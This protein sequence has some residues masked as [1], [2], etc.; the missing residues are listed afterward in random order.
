MG[1]LE[2]RGMPRIAVGG[3]QLYYEESGHGPPLVFLSGLGGDHRSF[4][5]PIRFFAARYRVLA[6]DY[7]DVGRSDRA[8]APYTTA[9][10]ADDVAGWLRALDVPPARVVGHSLG[11]LI[12]QE[13]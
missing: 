10:L 7:R 4:S 6:L 3:R 9:D 2:G 1:D 11:G 5:V 13:L 12:A 8:E